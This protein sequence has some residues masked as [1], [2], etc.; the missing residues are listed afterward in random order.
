MVPEKYPPGFKKLY[1]TPISFE[2]LDQ[3]KAGSLKKILWNVKAVICQ[4]F[5]NFGA[6]FAW[7][8]LI[9]TALKLG[10]RLHKAG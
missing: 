6:R 2:Q 5:A 3:R 7:E 10:V 4:V 1:F 8:H 9:L